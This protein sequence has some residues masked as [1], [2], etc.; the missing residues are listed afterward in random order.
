MRL[1]IVYK[2]ITQSKLEFNKGSRAGDRVARHLSGYR[3]ILQ[4]DGYGAY[5]KLA[6]SDGGNDGMML[7][8]CWSH[9]R[10]KFYELHASD[11]S[12]IA[13][14]TVELMAKLWE[15]EETAPGQSPDARVAARQ[16]THLLRLSRSSSPSGRRPCR[17]SPASRSSQRRSAHLASLNL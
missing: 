3:G 17:G 11:S 15:V 16:A 9:T 14:E 5:N 7:A 6:R 13:T 2:L 10:R 4:V 8:G 1:K 12:R